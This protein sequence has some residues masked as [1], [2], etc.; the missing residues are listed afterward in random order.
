MYSNYARLY[1]NCNGSLAGQ[2]SSKRYIIPSFKN[3]GKVSVT[4]DPDDEKKAGEIYVADSLP[5]DLEYRYT[6]MKT[7]EK[8]VKENFMIPQTCDFKLVE[9]NT[10]NNTPSSSEPVMCSMDESGQ[11]VC[12][13]SEKLYAILDPRFNLRETAKHLILLEDH[14]FHEG[15]RCKDCILKHLLTIEGFLEEAITLDKTGEYTQMIQ[16]TINNFRN[17]FKMVAEKVDKG[18]MTDDE[19]CKL[20]QT[21]RGIRKP[22]CQKYAGFMP[23]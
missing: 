9:Y 6:T 22:L 3:Y 11:S 8:P 10:S 15:K 18:E 20:A 14:L 17:V 23:N 5:R 1:Q 16:E 4:F 2:T 19:C 13:N 12:G 21:L 7:E